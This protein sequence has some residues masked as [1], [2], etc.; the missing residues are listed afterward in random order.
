MRV[1]AFAVLVSAVVAANLAFVLLGGSFD[2]P[3]VLTQDS[4]DVLRRFHAN[5]AVAWEFVLLAVSAA[6]LAPAAVLTARLA[7]GA[8][9]ARAVGV[10]AAVVQVV[11]LLRWPL[12][13]PGLSPDVPAD[14]ERFELLNTVLGNV[15]GEAGGYL[16]TAAWTVLV[17]RALRPGRLSAA[18]AL[19][20]AAGI[21]GGVVGLGEVNFVGYVVWSGWVLWLAVWILVRGRHA[22]KSPTTV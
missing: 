19:V 21:L 11:G 4:T 17:V 13:V 1:L 10:A 8:P 22:A 12:L 15:I 6:L 7:G 5:P 9:V 3:D 14:V 20:S 18:V 16:L 2:Y